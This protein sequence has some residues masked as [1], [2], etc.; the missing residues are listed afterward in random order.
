M[1][2]GSGETGHRTGITPLGEE[3]KKS[4]TCGELQKKCHVGN[5]LVSNVFACG[6]RRKWGGNKPKWVVTRLKGNGGA[7]RRAA[8]LLGIKRFDSPVGAGLVP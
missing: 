3:V 8:I 1:G 6:E 5:P 4:V 7:Q 2:V